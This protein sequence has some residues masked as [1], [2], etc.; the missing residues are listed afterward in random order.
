MGT[1]DEPSDPDDPAPAHLAAGR[2]G[3]GSAA[4]FGVAAAAPIVT[5]VTVIPPVLAVGAGPLA[6]LAVVA[7]A[8]VLLILGTPYATMIRRRPSAGAVYPQLARGLGRPVAVTG[9]WLALAGYHA[10]QFGLYAMLGQAA[11]PVLHSWFGLTAPWWAVTAAGWALVGWCGMLR[12]E[13]AAAV[14]AVLTVTEAAV[15]TGLAAANLL[16]PAGGRIETGTYLPGELSRVGR[17]LLG[18]LLVVAVLAFAGFESTAGYAEEAR[19]RHRTAGRAARL[20]IGLLTVLLAGVTWSMIVTAGPRG[21]AGRAAARGPELLFALA[22]ERVAPWAVTLGRLALVAGLLAAIMAVHHAIAR[23]LFALGREGVLPGVLADLSPRTGAPRAASLTQTLVAGAASTG[24]YLAGAETSARTARWLTVG[25]GLAILVLLLLTALAALLH[26]NREPA[27]EGIWARFLAP[28]LSTVFLG[29]LVHLAV[30]DL[31]A[32]VGG[33]PAAGWVLGGL[34][35][36]LAIGIGHA[37]VLRSVRPVVYAGIGLGGAALVVTPQT[38]VQI[39]KQRD[40]GA[41]RPERVNR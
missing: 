19:N 16:R 37:L 5:V 20:A 39:P 18:V 15:L 33:G 22:D 36:C 12:I 21:V 7:V 38:A 13:F 8:I 6:A 3:A 10:I 40:P 4:F 30:L 29:V 23:Y 14:L 9:G 34:A 28:L 11:A 1:P 35:V 2:L 32:L 25:G 31:P 27:T 17:P 24:A 26:L 41:H